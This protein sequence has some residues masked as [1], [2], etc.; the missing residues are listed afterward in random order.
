MHELL[1]FFFSINRKD[2]NGLFPF[3]YTHPFN[4]LTIQTDDGDNDGDN[5]TSKCLGYDTRFYDVVREGDVFGTSRCVLLLPKN[6]APVH[7]L[8]PRSTDENYSSMLNLTSLEDEDAETF[9]AGAFTDS[10]EELVFQQEQGGVFT[11]L[12]KIAENGLKRW[13]AQREAVRRLQEEKKEKEELLS[14]MLAKLASAAAAAA[15]AQ[16]RTSSSAAAKPAEKH[17]VVGFELPLGGCSYNNNDAASSSSVV[18][19]EASPRPASLLSLQ[20]GKAAAPAEESA[21]ANPNTAT[22]ES[23]A[24]NSNTAAA[25]SATEDSQ[26]P[27]SSPSPPAEAEPAGE[28]P[29]PATPEQLQTGDVRESEEERREEERR[30]HAGAGTGLVELMD[31]GWCGAVEMPRAE[32]QETWRVEEEERRRRKRAEEQQQRRRRPNLFARCKAAAT[33]WARKD[34]QPEVPIV[35]M[36]P[37]PGAGGG[38]RWARR[39]R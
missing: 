35:L 31:L 33:S 21:A 2:V 38:G 1:S 14:K 5:D 28:T 13:E 15:A 3:S 39:R 12:F 37:L 30:W 25:E 7:P 20:L 22:A 24:A 19:N 36:S 34:V 8:D 26:S 16:A 32:V 4:L 29:A 6:A 18:G 27:S 17:V 10:S 11:L 23:A 9:V